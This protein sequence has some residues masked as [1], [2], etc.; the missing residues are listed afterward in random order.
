MRKELANFSILLIINDVT[1]QLCNAFS[2]AAKGAFL[3]KFQK[4]G[5][6]EHN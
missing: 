6:Y 2:L 5:R 1:C 4:G 3:L